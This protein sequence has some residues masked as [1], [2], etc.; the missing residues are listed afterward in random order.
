MKK[1]KLITLFLNQRGVG[2]VGALIAAALV[3]TIAM[4][5]AYVVSDQSRLSKRIEI[6]GSCQNIANSLVEYIKKD[7]TSLFISSYGPAGG[8]DFPQGLDQTDDGIDRF[9]FTSTPIPLYTGTGALSLPPTATQIPPPWKYFN[10]LNIKNSTNRL[11]ALAASGNFCCNGLDMGPNCGER[12]YDDSTPRPGFTITD[13]NVEID[14]AV[15]F[16]GI[17]CT[18]R[19]LAIA[20]LPDSQDTTRA[21]FK[22]RVT[23]QRGTDQEKSCTG[24]G[25]VQRATDTTPALTLI[26]YQNL[27]GPGIISPAIC[28]AP[29]PV[30]IAIRTFKSNAG[31]ACQTN[32]QQQINS[33]T[34]SDATGA[35]PDLFDSFNNAACA[36]C[37]ESEPGTA[38]LCRIGEKTWFDNPTNANVWEPCENAT[39]KDADGTTAGNVS[40]SYQPLVSGNDNTQRTAN[41]VL[42]LSGLRSMKGYVVDVRT[43]D[44]SGNVGPSFCNPTNGSPSCSSASPAH[45]SIIDS[46]PVM[47][48]ISENTNHVANAGTALGSFSPSLTGTSAPKYT[49]AM[50]AFAGG[51]FQCQG[52]APVFIGSVVYTPPL[53]PGPSSISHNCS[54][55]LT[56]PGGATTIIPPAAPGVTPGC[57]CVGADCT[58]R[59]PAVASEG[60][61]TLSLSAENNCE[62]LPAIPVQSWCLDSTTTI[63]ATYSPSENFPTPMP[64]F[65]SVITEAS[66][67]AKACGVATLCPNLD[68]SFTPTL[69]A[70]CGTGGWNNTTNSGCTQDPL[71]NFCAIV[72]D[73]CGRYQQN[74]TPPTRYSTLLESV[75]HTSGSPATNHCFRYGGTQRGGNICEAGSYCSRIG[76]CLNTCAKAGT[77]CTIAAECEDP[78]YGVT[79]A[80]VGGPTCTGNICTCPT[81]N[82]SPAAN[83]CSPVY[84]PVLNS[85]TSGIGTPQGPTSCTPCSNWNIGAWGACVGSQRTRTVNCPTSCCIGPMPST[86]ISCPECQTPWGTE[87]ANGATVTAYQTS[88]VAC[89]STCISENRTC[90]NGILSGSFTNQNCSV[91]ACTA[92]CWSCFGPNAECSPGPSSGCGYNG[93]TTAHGVPNLVGTACAN[94]GDQ[95]YFQRLL[96]IGVVCSQGNIE[97][98]AC[99]GTNGACGS[100]HGT[101]G[102][103]APTSLCNAGTASAVSGSGPWTW[104]CAGTGS[105]TIADCTKSYSIPVINGVC[106]TSNGTAVASAPTTN[107]CSSG[108]ASTVTGAG[109]WS[110][111]CEGSGGGGDAGCSAS[112]GAMVNGV[113]GTANGTTVASAP[114]TNLCSSGTASAVAGSGPWTWNCLGSGG[115]SNSFCSANATGGFW[116]FNGMEDSS[117]GCRGASDPSILNTPCS[118]LG[119]IAYEYVAVCP[120]TG[121]QVRAYECR[122]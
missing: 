76:K 24:T 78:S 39:V 81:N 45:F 87:I 55:L 107:L 102:P 6:A 100:D 35:G 73:P 3:I 51:K 54:G 84:C 14:L 71:G 65:A 23:I 101:S 72:V 115:G 74:T 111:S 34:C 90:N 119:D 2:L 49:D 18:A 5:V 44:T 22:V 68:A 103:T 67:P 113:C 122:P 48:P 112:V 46:A 21:E 10:Y 70:I 58:A 88:S 30:Q 9:R 106:G 82:S 97:C 62:T 105:G 96:P 27:C 15:D 86:T 85:C 19:R 61:Y 33:T 108:T 57:N 56:S 28:G 32:C 93:Y 40:I 77:A 17:P 63:G 94:V 66:A 36:A 16:D 60:G 104:S 69:G 25:I 52:G 117:N 37:L 43:V 38:F 29:A 4:T 7:E 120:T 20:D 13:R 1:N 109:P 80:E 41:A 83:D 11:I 95:Q 98:I 89:A 31:T 59:L 110:W 12:F 47:G 26:Q 75:P 64:S 91:S 116:R 118:P 42:T 8:V 121:I 114:T 79:S 50:V 53:P 92:G 99:G